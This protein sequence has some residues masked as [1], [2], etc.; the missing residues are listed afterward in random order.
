MATPLYLQFSLSSQEIIIQ[1]LRFFSRDLMSTKE[2]V[3]GLMF[4]F[5]TQTE[6]C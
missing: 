6:M 2:A 4:I 5:T 3:T 1:A